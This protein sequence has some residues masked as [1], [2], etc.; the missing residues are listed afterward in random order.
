[1]E[2]M[3]RVQKSEEKVKNV[4]KQLLERLSLRNSNKKKVVRSSGISQTKEDISIGRRFSVGIAFKSH[5][6]PKKTPDMM[7]RTVKSSFIH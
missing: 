1:M 6:P 3:S 5:C 4:F 2:M 7:T